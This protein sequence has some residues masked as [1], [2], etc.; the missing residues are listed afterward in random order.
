MSRIQDLSVCS[1]LSTG[2]FIFKMQLVNAHESC[3][4]L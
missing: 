2:G 4:H 1:N 3:Q